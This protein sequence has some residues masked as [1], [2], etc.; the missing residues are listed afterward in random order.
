LG[1]SWLFLAAALFAMAVVMRQGI[2]LLVALLLLI[3]YAVAQIWARY[4][5][6]RL[7]YSRHLSTTRAF[8]GD[9]VTL[10]LSLA[11][12]KILP[13]PW[14]QV[15]EELDETLILPPAVITSPSHRLGRVML[16]NVMPLS[17]YHR[18]K[19][20][21]QFTCLKRGYFSFGPTRIQSGDYFRFR[22][23]ETEVGDPAYLMVY[24]KIL[25]IEQLGIPSRDPFGDLR[26]RRHLF[27]DPVRVASIRDYT[28]GD[29]LKRIHWKA[30]ARV[31]K[32][33]TK[34]FEHTTSP[35]LALFLDVRTVKQPFWGEVTQL[36]EMGTIA[37]ASIADH[38][39]HKGYRV[40]LYVN[41]PY[42]SSGLLVKLPPSSHPDQL[43][44]ILEALAMVTPT[45]S[46]SF[47]KF[48]R[49]EGGNLPWVSTLVAITAVPTPALVSVLNTFHQV[50]RPVTLIIVGAGESDFPAN[51]LLKYNIPAEI[52]WDKVE[53]VDLN[54]PE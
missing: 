39:V 8:F 50:G 54:P 13:L 23:R 45:E 17:W 51:G 44:H 32:L 28:P 2:L 7:E 37:T 31:G 42:P 10:E 33:Q 16:R 52:I 26:L 15:E 9:T 27:Q 29:P 24:P 34:V 30:S 19:R 35:D 4:A 40:G 11:N 49:Q 1:K 5:L 25:P 41:Q 21:Y 14:V 38:L 18:V 6:R 43:T 36:L 22:V 3:L 12:R 53:S 48:V 47:D 20:V 46:I